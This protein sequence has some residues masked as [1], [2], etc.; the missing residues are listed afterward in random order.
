MYQVSISA[1]T[2]INLFDTVPGQHQQIARNVEMLMNSRP[3]QTIA[4][5]PARCRKCSFYEA[6]TWIGGTDVP[7]KIDPVKPYRKQSL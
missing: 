1:W 5:R 2:E 4:T 3:F 6:R 7:A